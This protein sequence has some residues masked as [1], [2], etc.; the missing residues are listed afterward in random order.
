MTE[1][2]SEWYLLKD[3]EFLKE[4]STK[5]IVSDMQLR[6]L[7][8]MKYAPL[9]FNKDYVQEFIEREKLKKMKDKNKMKNWECTLLAIAF[10]YLTG[11]IIFVIQQG[12]WK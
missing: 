2:Y 11:L 8:C 10:G 7:F 12:F 5:Y 6:R 1:N 3:L 9:D 4:T